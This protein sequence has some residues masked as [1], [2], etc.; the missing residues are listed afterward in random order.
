MNDPVRYSSINKLTSI[1]PPDEAIDTAEQLLIHCYSFGRVAHS[2]D[3]L[4]AMSELN[5]SDSLTYW[6]E[7]IGF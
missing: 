2:L 7:V 4:R 5:Q 3:E 1:P 6:Y